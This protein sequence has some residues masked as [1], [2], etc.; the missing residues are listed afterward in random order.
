[1]KA[2]VYVVCD[3]IKLV[4]VL[5]G[6]EPNARLLVVLTSKYHCCTSFSMSETNV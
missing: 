1:V 4:G 3:K 5:V 6:K 2:Q